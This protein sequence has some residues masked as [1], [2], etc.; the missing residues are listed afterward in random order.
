MLDE[1]LEQAKQQN[2]EKRRNL[3]ILLTVAGVV[4]AVVIV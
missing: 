3:V 4:C 2:A 1:Q